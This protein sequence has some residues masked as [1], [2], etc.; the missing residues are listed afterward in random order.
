[1]P[2][3]T[4]NIRI[5]C[6]T[7]YLTSHLI[8]YLTVY[9]I[10]FL[11]SLFSCCDVLVLGLH[12]ELLWLALPH[13]QGCSVLADFALELFLGSND[14]PLDSTCLLEQACGFIWLVWVFGCCL[15]DDHYSE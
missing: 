5:I 4:E 10:S 9:K 3:S 13:I 6:L 12:L 7:V 1:M 8:I 15:P 14:L 11:V 2:R